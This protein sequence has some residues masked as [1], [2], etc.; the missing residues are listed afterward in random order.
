MNTGGEIVSLV[1]I[2]DLIERNV[3]FKVIAEFLNLKISSVLPFIF[4][5]SMHIPASPHCPTGDCNW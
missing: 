5:S 1:F 4:F 2:C 3:Y